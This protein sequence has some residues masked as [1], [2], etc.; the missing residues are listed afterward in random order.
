M[1]CVVD[2]D[3]PTLL[4]REALWCIRSYASTADNIHEKWSPSRKPTLH[5][6]PVGHCVFSQQLQS[7][8]F[9]NAVFDPFG[10]DLCT[11]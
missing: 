6:C 4:H 8:R 1:R 11:R 10:V 7:L 5:L 3:S 2:K 9:Y